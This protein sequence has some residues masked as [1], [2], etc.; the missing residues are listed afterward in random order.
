MFASGQG[1]GCCFE[2]RSQQGADARSDTFMSFNRYIGDWN[3]DSVREMWGMFGGATAFNQNISKKDVTVGDVTYTAWDTS[4]VTIMR[5]MFKGAEAFNQ[6]LSNWK[7][8]EGI[9]NDEFLQFDQDAIRWCGVGFENQGRPIGITP[10]ESRRRCVQLNLT[11][12]VGGDEVKVVNKG[13]TVIYVAEFDNNSESDLKNEQ[14]A[15]ILPPGTE[16]NSNSS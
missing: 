16:W 6:N 8:S 7:V 13:Q 10:G 4:N 15:F 2:C 11:P 1:D 5:Q 12:T 3:T 9:T 14:F